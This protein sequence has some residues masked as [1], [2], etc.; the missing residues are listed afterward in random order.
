MV[1]IE[2]SEVVA[3]FAE[4]RRSSGAIGLEDF[5]GDGGPHIIEHLVNLISADILSELEASFTARQ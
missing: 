3:E 1:A 5:G 2:S 4:R